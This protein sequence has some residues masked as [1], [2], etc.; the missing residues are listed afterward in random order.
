[1]ASSSAWR[2][3]RGAGAVTS[4][5]TRRQR[6]IREGDHCPS[7]RETRRRGPSDRSPRKPGC[8]GPIRPGCAYHPALGLR[9]AS[10]RRPHRVGSQPR[11]RRLLLTPAE[12]GAY[13]PGP[14]PV[15]GARSGGNDLLRFT[16]LASAFHG[17]CA[18][19]ADRPLTFSPFGATGTS[20]SAGASV[21]WN[22]SAPRYG[23]RD[24]NRLG[25]IG[26]ACAKRGTVQASRPRVLTW[27]QPAFT[28]VRPGRGRRERCVCAPRRCRIGLKRAERAP[29]RNEQGHQ[30]SR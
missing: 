2:A 30:R 27:R 28:P 25:T 29:G 1:M 5:A 17:S 14:S 7:G 16:G 12:F 20:V 6:G 4:S 22:T 13:P 23:A 19:R 10:G 8:V 3:R 21:L 26:I 18:G 24:G 9:G 11:R 15:S